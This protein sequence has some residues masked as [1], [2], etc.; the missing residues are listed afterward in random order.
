[1]FSFSFKIGAGDFCVGGCQAIADTG[2]SLIAGPTT[3]I[4]KIN[5]LIGA[6]PIPFT[7]EVRISFFFNFWALLV[8]YHLTEA[9]KTRQY[10]ISPL[11][12]TALQARSV[13]LRPQALHFPEQRETGWYVHIT[14]HAPKCQ[15]TKSAKVCLH[16]FQVMLSIS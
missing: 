6:F 3:E 7:G 4:L 12:F 10:R 9:S 1:M 5:T 2:T 8:H 13:L 14:S 11:L 15:W 16:T